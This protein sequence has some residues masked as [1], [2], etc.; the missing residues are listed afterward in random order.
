MPLAEFLFTDDARLDSYFEQIAAPVMYDKVPV[1][2]AS[3]SLWPIRRGG[4]EP[5]RES[6]HAL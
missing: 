5:C 4:S 2:K 1:W 6:P 3:L